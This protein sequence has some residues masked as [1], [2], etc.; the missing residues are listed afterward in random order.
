MDN[1]LKLCSKCGLNEKKPMQTY[2]V[3]CI[4][5]Y[6]KERYIKKRE[7]ILKRQN[8]YHEANRKQ[9]NHRNKEYKLKNL[10]KCI[11]LTKNWKINNKSKVNASNGKRRANLRNAL[12]KWLTNDELWMIEQA[13]DLAQLRTKVF[14]FKWHV[15]HVIPL[16][17]KN[18]CGLHTPYNLQVI[19]AKENLRKRNFF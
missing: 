6:Q 18:V 19:P 12:P 15:D 17:G 5:A 9:V 14:G 16:K 4:S 8:E 3:G 7:S 11:N 1:I 2:C 13:Y 10:E